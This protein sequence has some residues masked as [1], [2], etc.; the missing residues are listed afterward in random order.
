MNKE[1]IK[2]MNKEELIRKE[3]KLINVTI[4][5]LILDVITTITALYLGA[6]E[7]NPIL[8]YFTQF[9]LN[10]VT[11]VVI[12]H[13][14]AIGILHSIKLYYRKKKEIKLDVITFIFIV[15]CL[16]ALAV[17]NNTIHIIAL[18]Y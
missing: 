8:L 14:I 7:S 18:L 1:E 3:E 2:K 9:G 5:L 4:V 6:I 10:I 13:I 16:Y 15:M 12:S 11:I 17:L